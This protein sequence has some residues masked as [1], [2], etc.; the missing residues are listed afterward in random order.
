LVPSSGKKRPPPPKKRAEGG[1]RGH[2]KRS[3]RNKR[4]LGLSYDG[5]WG[6]VN[7]VRFW[8]NSKGLLAELN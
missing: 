2:L 5:A 6:V 3:S 8:M 1:V 7:N 4:S